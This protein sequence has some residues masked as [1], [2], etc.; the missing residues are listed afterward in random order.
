V[1]GKGWNSKANL[2]GSGPLAAAG[3]LCP[4]QKDFPSR[5]VQQNYQR[6]KRNQ[7][8]EVR[9][10][11]LEKRFFCS[12]QPVKNWSARSNTPARGR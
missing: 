2:S 5:E 8:E 11:S 1:A 4:R 12:A 7:R 10:R 3:V 6:R 9:V